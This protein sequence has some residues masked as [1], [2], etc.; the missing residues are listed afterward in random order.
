MSITNDSQLAQPQGSEKR[1][2]GQRPK[3]VVAA[4]IWFVLIGLVGCWN[5]V[6]L[7]GQMS[8]IDWTR[9]AHQLGVEVELLKR[10]FTIQVYSTFAASLAALVSSIAIWAM[11]KWGTLICL[12]LIGLGAAGLI[13]AQYQRKLE[14][15]D[16]V[17]LGINV[18]IGIG[19]LNLWR[20]GQLT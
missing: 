5:S 2:R 12:L 18:V 6:K 1:N 20:K 19:L 8:Q 9:A 15:A 14:P 10:T 16:F 11:K 7:L 13:M 4:A 3:W 17:G